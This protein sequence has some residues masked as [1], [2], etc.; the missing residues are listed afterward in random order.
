M[1]PEDTPFGRIGVVVD[2]FGAVFGLHSP[3]AGR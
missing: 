1:A 2:P 3:P